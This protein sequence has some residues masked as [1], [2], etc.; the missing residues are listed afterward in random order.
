MIWNAVDWA[1]RRVDPGV[2]ASGLR[3]FGASG[4]P[5][6]MLH[7][8]E[9]PAHGIRGHDPAV[10]RQLLKEIRAYGIEAVSLEDVISGRATHSSSR[11]RVAFTMDDGYRDQA[12]LGGQIFAEAGVPLTIFVV[13]GLLS[14]EHWP[15]DA[16]LRFVL[17]EASE[18]AFLEFLRRERIDVEEGATLSGRRAAFYQLH[19]RFLSAS[20][21]WVEDQIAEFASRLD[22][23]VTRVPPGHYRGMS[24]DDARR[25]EAMGITFAPHSHSHYAFP[26]L[27]KAD[28]EREVALSWDGVQR[29]LERPLKVFAFPNGSR[30]DYGA[31]D[32][33]ILRRF[34]FRAAV[35]AH[36]G[37]VQSPGAQGSGEP[38]AV[39]PRFSL[40]DS[41]ARLGQ[42]A[43]GLARSST[44]DDGPLRSPPRRNGRP[45]APPTSPGAPLGGT[46][47]TCRRRRS[48]RI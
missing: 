47:P 38:V 48:S 30:T 8:F 7:R 27:S 43:L 17:N 26:M 37:Y 16:R 35:A 10:V 1:L 6:F 33:T 18:E 31:R 21:P 39:I 14:E 9:D 25:L 24:W 15:W 45:N 5:V 29:E 28:V 2:L 40:P 11:R 41:P 44:V 23:S 42:I 32:L 13:T 20:A 34:G 4:V 12:I 36:A 46:G 3:R 19:D 22:V